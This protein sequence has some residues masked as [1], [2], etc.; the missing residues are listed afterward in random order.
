MYN[1]GFEAYFKQ[2]RREGPGPGTDCPAKAE[3]MNIGEGGT[4]Q[5]VCRHRPHYQQGEGEEKE[6][7][8]SVCFD[9]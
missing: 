5:E 6:Y 7:E 2:V 9:V 8:C 4:E 3:E 1:K